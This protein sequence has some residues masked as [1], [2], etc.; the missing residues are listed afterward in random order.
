MNRI[1]KQYIKASTIILDLSFLNLSLFI[2]STLIKYNFFFETIFYENIFIIIN[3][4]WLVLSYIFGLYGNEILNHYEYFIKRSLQVFFFWAFCFLIYIIWVRNTMLTTYHVILQIMN[5]GIGLVIVRFFHAGL[6]NYLREKNNYKNKVVIIGFN[7]TA[8]KLAS[9]LEEEG[10]NMQLL[11]FSEDQFNVKELSNYPILCSIN[12][13]ISTAKKLQAT[14]IFSTISPTENKYIS[15]ILKE[16]EN[17]CMRFKL[18][19]DLRMSSIRPIVVDYIKDLPILSMRKDP[20]EDIG[21]KLKKRFLDIAVSFF[22]VILILSWLIPLIG[23]LILIESRGPIF[24]RQ[25]RTGANDRSFY[26]LKFRSMKINTDADKKSATRDDSRITRIGS[27]LRKTS[28]DEFP[29][30]INVLMGEMSLVGPRPH[31]LKHTY[32]FSKTVNHYMVRQLLKPGITGW[33]QINNLRGEIKTQE[34]IKKRVECDLWYLEN[35]S[36]WLDIKITF[37]TIYQVISSNEKAY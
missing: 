17:N 34:D 15:S 6:Y 9:Y 7:E 5:F 37:A 33:A 23:I 10:M 25:L 2:V 28:L 31:M 24:F 27:F 20:L 21:N 8:K 35:W 11:G 3:L 12:K 36:I 13:T 18:V 16:A 29:Q 4:E 1:L 22:V 19:P 32:E 30:F 14:E 26:C